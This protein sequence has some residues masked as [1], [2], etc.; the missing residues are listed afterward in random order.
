M[1]EFIKRQIIEEV[2]Q[3]II[4]DK[5]NNEKELKDLIEVVAE[6]KMKK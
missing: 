1:F 3:R 5:P 4:E 6:E 2:S